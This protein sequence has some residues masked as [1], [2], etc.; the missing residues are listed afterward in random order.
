[1]RIADWFGLPGVWCSPDCVDAFSPKVIQAGM[2]A[3]F[4]VPV[5][6]DV[7]LADLVQNTPDLAV[8]GAVMDGENVFQTVLPTRAL[9]VIGNEGRG[10]PADVEALLTHRVTIPRGVA[11]S[12][13]ESLNAGVAAGIL[14]AQF[15]KK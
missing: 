12:G 8:V 5:F 2:G 3:C 6:E 10:I 4:R 9:L 15:V 14:V 13:A 7:Q 11:N 1:L